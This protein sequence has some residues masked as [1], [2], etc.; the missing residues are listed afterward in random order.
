[1]LQHASFARDDRSGHDGLHVPVSRSMDKSSQPQSPKVLSADEIVRAKE[2]ERSRLASAAGLSGRPGHSKSS[3]LDANALL[4]FASRRT[5]ARPGAP[6]ILP[7]QVR[8]H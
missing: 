7:P 2:K 3:R 4:D 5:L 8:A 6:P 1:M